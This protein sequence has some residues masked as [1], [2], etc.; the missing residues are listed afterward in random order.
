MDS[1]FFRGG[2][3]IIKTTHPDIQA[4]LQSAIALLIG[5]VGCLLA[6]VISAKLFP[7][8]RT[9]SEQKFSENDRERVL[10]ELQINIEEERRYMEEMPADV[11]REMKE[12]EL[13]RLFDETNPN[14]PS[15]KK[16][17]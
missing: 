8:K 12:L 16:E 6:A 3:E 10:H 17:A 9:L 1:V 13:D 5:I 11:R 15:L 7:P 14:A 2:I 4:S